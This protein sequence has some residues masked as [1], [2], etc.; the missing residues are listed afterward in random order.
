MCSNLQDT[1]DETD[2]PERQ[3][4]PMMKRLRSSNALVVPEDSPPQRGQGS[5]GWLGLAA[6]AASS[7]R[8]TPKEPHKP[9]KKDRSKKVSTAGTKWAPCLI[10]LKT[11]KDP[12]LRTT[13]ASAGDSQHMNI[14]LHYI[15]SF[16]LS[17]C[18]SV[19]HLSVKCV[20]HL[21]CRF[22]SIYLFLLLHSHVH[23]TKN[24]IPMCLF[25]RH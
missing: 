6:A 9:V 20:V 16:S 21:C 24:Q 11:P 22:V 10:C 13:C 8:A 7:E 17:P 14:T 5:A 2:A 23:L 19:S 4:E 1:E 18:L 25:E 12:P 3:P 15:L